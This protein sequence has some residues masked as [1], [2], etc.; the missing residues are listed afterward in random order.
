MCPSDP[1]DNYPFNFSPLLKMTDV[2]ANDNE[3]GEVVPERTEQ[4]YAEN[5]IRLVSAGDK[6]L[7]QGLAKEME[8]LL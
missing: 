1:T 8:I 5:V 2:T 6:A 3:D 7:Q 4:A